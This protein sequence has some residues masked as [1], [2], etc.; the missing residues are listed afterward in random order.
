[1][2]KLDYRLC[3]AELDLEFLC[4]CNDNNVIPKFLNFRVANNHLTFSTTYKQCQSNLLNEEIGQKKST[5]QI[6]QKEFTSLKS[7]L[8]Y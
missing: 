3:K 1:M 2:E 5:V 6:L 8:Q 7:S 4:K